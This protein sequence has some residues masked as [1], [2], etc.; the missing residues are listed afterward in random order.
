MQWA[1]KSAGDER[2]TPIPVARASEREW[3]MLHPV[4]A[5]QDTRYHSPIRQGGRTTTL[6]GNT[7]SK[8]VKTRQD[9]KDCENRESR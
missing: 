4:L 3:F 7:T 2:M 6:S 1:G 8:R 9:A 5:A